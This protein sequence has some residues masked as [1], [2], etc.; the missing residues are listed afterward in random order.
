MRRPRGLIALGLLIG[1]L[2]LLLAA[3]GG[4]SETPSA[5]D[6]S[7][8]ATPTVGATEPS[9]TAPEAGEQLG[10][11]AAGPTPTGVPGPGGAVSGTTE[12]PFRVLALT[13]SILPA[14]VQALSAKTAIQGRPGYPQGTAEPLPAD[15]L[16]QCCRGDLSRL[17][18]TLDELK[19]AVDELLAVY[20]T[21]N[22]TEGLASAQRMVYQ[23]AG[24]HNTLAALPGLSDIRAVQEKVAGVVAIGDALRD[25]ARQILECCQVSTAEP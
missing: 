16:D 7:G 14:Q 2:A 15:W 1:L 24:L 17:L 9:P 23:I 5:A 19:A 6:G 25:T 13:L 20:E 4:D 12:S 8:T 21:A 22:H 10:E 18:E 3:C 11:T